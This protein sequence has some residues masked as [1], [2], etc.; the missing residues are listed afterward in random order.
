MIKKSRC[1]DCKKC[2]IADESCLLCAMAGYREFV[3]DDKKIIRRMSYD[4]SAKLAKKVSQNRL[5]N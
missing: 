3:E 2:N 4:K 5:K 1:F